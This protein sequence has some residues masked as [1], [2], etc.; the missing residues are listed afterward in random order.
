M[1]GASSEV[2]EDTKV[3]ALEAAYWEPRPSRRTAKALGMHT[4]ASHRFERGADP[5]A[6][7]TATARL[8]HLLEKIGAGSSA[9]RAHRGRR[10]P[11]PRRSVSLRPSRVDAVL[12]TAVPQERTHAILAGLGFG[13]SSA[14]DGTLGTEVPSWRGDVSREADVI[15]E[16]A[17]TIGFAQRRPPSR[18]PARPGGLRPAQDRE[19]ARPRPARCGGTHRGHQPGLRG[20]HEDDAFGVAP[21]GP[22]EPP[23]LR[24]R[25]APRPRSFPG[26]ARE[27]AHQPAAGPPGR[28][29]LRDRAG[30]R[31]PLAGE[32]LPREERR[33]AFVLCGRAA[34][35]TGPSGIGRSTSST[36]RG[37]SSVLAE[38]LDAD[39]RRRERPSGPARLSSTPAER[40]DPRDV[41]AAR[42]R[43]VAAP[44][45]AAELDLRDEVVVAELE[46]GALPRPGTV[47]LRTRPLERFPAVARDLSVVCD[48]RRARG[49]SPRSRP[50][51]R[52]RGC[53]GRGDPRSVRGAIRCPQGK[54]S[55]TIGLRFQ[56]P[57]GHSPARR[58]R[59]RWSASCAT[60]R[61]GAEIRGE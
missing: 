49:R 42:L 22:P 21:G 38:R 20:E 53:S 9:A 7:A 26:L 35:G 11:R 4:E 55:L 24:P 50:P 30:V 48:V 12:G 37:S 1:G 41:G 33:L 13:V 28:G 58:S 15:E 36:R 61:A 19:R 18:P 5:E 60:F 8:A 17:G 25:P 27:P 40:P 44:R 34:R 23:V 59:P 10:R 32:A 31:A 56:D 51:R 39:R 3:V 52:G 43:G 16:V 14:P 6:P 2:S 47:P 46:P 54:V 29:A 57:P 45:R